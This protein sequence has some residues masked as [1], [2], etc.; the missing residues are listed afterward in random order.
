DAHPPPAREMTPR[1]PPQLVVGQRHEAVERLGLTLSKRRQRVGFRHRRLGGLHVLPPGCRD[2]AIDIVS[3]TEGVGATSRPPCVRGVI[4]AKHAPAWARGAMAILTKNGMNILGG[5]MH[6]RS[7]AL[8]VG[9]GWLLCAGAC[10]G[11][12]AT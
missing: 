2:S 10:G 5:V 7:A 9:S 12:N 4:D 1:D 8:L 11:D 3:G 6:A